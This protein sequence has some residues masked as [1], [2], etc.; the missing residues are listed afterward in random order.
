MCSRKF[1]GKVGHVNARW[2]WHRVKRSSEVFGGVR[3]RFGIDGRG[4]RRGAGGD[5]VDRQGRGGRVGR[6]ESGAIERGIDL[7]IVGWGKLRGRF[8]SGWDWRGEC[9]WEGVLEVWIEFEVYF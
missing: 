9:V 4:L 6:S 5:V 8:S 3:W 7:K 2:A 1:A